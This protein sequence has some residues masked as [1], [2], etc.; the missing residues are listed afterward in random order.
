M[1]IFIQHYQLNISIQWNHGFMQKDNWG[2]R[3]GEKKIIGT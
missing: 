1:F 2:Q 3:N